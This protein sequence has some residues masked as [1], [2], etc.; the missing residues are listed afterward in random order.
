MLIVGKQQGQ[1][2]NRPYESARRA[3][4]HLKSYEIVLDC[5]VNQHK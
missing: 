1:F 4:R 5:D 3:D 2:M